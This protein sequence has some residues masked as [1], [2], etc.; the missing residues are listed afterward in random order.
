MRDEIKQPA[1]LVHGG[2]YASIAESHR[3]DGDARRRRAAGRDGDGALEQHELPAAGHRRAPSTRARRACTAAA[4]PGCGT[5][6]SP[7]TP[8]ARCAR[9]ADDDRRRAARFR[10]RPTR[11]RGSAGAPA[12]GEGSGVEPK[13]VSGWPAGSGWPGAARAVDRDD[14]LRRRAGRA[15]G[16]GR[17]CRRR[18]APVGIA[19]ARPAS[20]EL[21]PVRRGPWPTSSGGFAAGQE[22]VVGVRDDAQRR[23]AG[24]LA[25]LQAVAV[26]DG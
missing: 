15:R 10:A 22:A 20:S 3:L 4:R 12:L 11:P 5:C 26:L 23:G 19:I 18:R 7:T 17:R 21:A 13:P 2:V 6:C 14:R 1:G 16:P 9:D 8:G 25:A 24:A